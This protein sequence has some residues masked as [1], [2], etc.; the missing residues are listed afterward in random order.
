MSKSI[1]IIED[2]SNAKYD[3]HTMNINDI[4][5]KYV[6]CTKRYKN[7]QKDKIYFIKKRGQNKD[8]QFFYLIKGRWVHD[9]YVRKLTDKELTVIKRKNV[10]KKLLNEKGA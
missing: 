7:I 1:H 2:N 4:S 10:I 6:Y 8:C 5:G 9:N 3:L